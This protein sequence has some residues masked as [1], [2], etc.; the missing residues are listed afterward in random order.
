MIKS[1]SWGMVWRQMGAD[2]HQ[3]LVPDRPDGHRIAASGFA[4]LLALVLRPV[5]ERWMF[6]RERAVTRLVLKE[7]KR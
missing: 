7:R 3:M 2:R 1:P 4:G 5:L 6:E